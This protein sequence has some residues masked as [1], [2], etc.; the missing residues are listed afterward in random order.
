[1]DTTPIQQWQFK[2]NENIGNYGS[3]PVNEKADNLKNQQTDNERVY[4]ILG[5]EG[6]KKLHGGKAYNENPKPDQTIDREAFIAAISTL[7]DRLLIDNEIKKKP[8][9]LGTISARALKDPNGKNLQELYEDAIR[10]ERESL[11]YKNAAFLKSVK[12]YNGGNFSNKEGEEHVIILAGPSGGGKTRAGPATVKAATHGVL[13]ELTDPADTQEHQHLVVTIDGGIERDTSQV[14][15]L[16]IRTSLKLGYGGIEDLEKITKNATKG[17]K[18][19]TIIEDAA[20]VKHMHLVIATTTPQKD[21][22]KYMGPDSKRKVTYAYVKT[23]WRTVDIIAYRRA[24]E[25][26]GTKCEGTIDDIEKPP[27]SKKPGGLL[28]YL[29]GKRAARQAKNEYLNRQRRNEAKRQKD[30]KETKL[31]TEPDEPAEQTKIL[32]ITKDLVFMEYVYDK[33]DI[34]K[35][36]PI[37]IRPNKKGKSM[38]ERQVAAWRTYKKTH[39]AAN[40]E[41]WYK[42]HEKD[43]QLVSEK[44]MSG[45]SKR[46]LQEIEEQQRKEITDCIKE[47][48]ANVEN[49]ID[50]L[51]TLLNL[52]LLANNTAIQFKDLFA[53]FEN[54]NPPLKKIT[55]PHSLPSKFLISL[56]LEKQINTIENQNT[57]LKQKKDRIEEIHNLQQILI[58]LNQEGSKFDDILQRIESYMENLALPEPISVPEASQP[59]PVITPVSMEPLPHQWPP[60]SQIIPK[61]VNVL[62]PSQSVLLTELQVTTVNTAIKDY[63]ELEVSEKIPEHDNKVKLL[64]IKGKDPV[65]A[66]NA[67]EELQK[68]TNLKTGFSEK[69]LYNL[70]ISGNKSKKDIKDFAMTQLMNC[71]EHTTITGITINKSP[72]EQLEFDSWKSEAAELKKLPPTLTAHTPTTPHI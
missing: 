21:L 15:K 71:G 60:M 4:K 53:L 39:P 50:G 51:T 47:I 22:D 54:I 43:E 28:S 25:Q 9:S 56:L 10:E 37:D 8:V 11:A 14:K 70:E 40:P 20:N 52:R 33:N 65:S 32:K 55:W 1:M 16:M 61:N 46:T 58:K 35:K 38:T 34:E 49:G 42:E 6:Y 72:L 26:I 24:F 48:N 29:L 2:K 68:I 41:S 57:S 31:S 30:P 62:S 23:P 12:V 63:A 19:K 13:D 45:T 64:G 69:I 59:S 18:L 17:P 44:I 27:E 67:C 36:V 3:K 66:V 7:G 5:A